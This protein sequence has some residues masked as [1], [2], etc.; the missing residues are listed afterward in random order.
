MTTALYHK[1]L[2]VRHNSYKKV[3]IISLNC[4]L[5]YSCFTFSKLFA[6]QHELNPYILK[7]ST[8]NLIFINFLK[9]LQPWYSLITC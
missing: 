2:C 5:T 7:Q 1:Y 6:R 8:L 3:V 9:A 4:T